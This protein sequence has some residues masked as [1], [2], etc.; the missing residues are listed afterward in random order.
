VIEVL[1]IASEE[2]LVLDLLRYRH[3][4][5]H[6]GYFFDFE[7][8]AFLVVSLLPEPSVFADALDRLLPIAAGE[9]S[10]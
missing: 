5:V 8:E 1:A 6:P 7:R 4:V 3:V 2:S 9:R 10:A